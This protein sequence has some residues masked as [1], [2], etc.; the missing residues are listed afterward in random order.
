MGAPEGEACAGLIEVLR[1]WDSNVQV[2]TQ[3]PSRELTI[4]TGTL[5]GIILVTGSF[6]LDL[7]VHS[8]S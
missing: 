4:D 1:L 2:P 8:S 6:K 3:S 7:F 5:S